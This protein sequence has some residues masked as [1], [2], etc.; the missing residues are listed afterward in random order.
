MAI[1]NSSLGRVGILGL[2]GVLAIGA[3]NV[4]SVVA[5][6]EPRSAQPV[7]APAMASQASEAP[8]AG[9][10]A[11]HAAGLQQ[12]QAAPRGATSDTPTAAEPTS[13][14]VPDKYA[15]AA[16]LQ[17][18]F[19]RR[20]P[21]GR[22][23]EQWQAAAP[24]SK[25]QDVSPRQAGFIVRLTNGRSLHVMQF[26]DKGE[27]VRVTQPHGTYELSKTLIASIKPRMIDPAVAPTG[28]GLR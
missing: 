26:D 21:T 15:L 27:T 5:Q 14:S 9:V 2:L 8:A 28:R 7:S 19:G 23:M 17:G 3:M 16:A 25:P 18:A 13:G 4:P 24:P 20:G 6:G 11:G 22:R 12:S 10:S 1:T